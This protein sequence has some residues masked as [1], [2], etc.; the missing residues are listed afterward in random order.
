M[1]KWPTLY[2]YTSSHVLLSILE[3]RSIWLGTRQ[4]LNDFNEGEVF[5]SHL[6][7]Y[8]STTGVKKANVDAVV[9]K[10][11]GLECYVNCMTTNGDQLSQWRGYAANGAGVSIGFNG[12]TLVQVI[13]GS[14]VALLRKVNY[15]DDFGTLEKETQDLIAAVLK[16]GGDPTCAFVQSLAKARWAIKNKAFEE[17]CEYRLILTPGPDDSAIVF[18]SG[19]TAVRKYRA[20]ESDIREYYELSFRNVD[21]NDLIQKVVLGPR[22][23][24][25]LDA[26]RRLLRDK[27]FTNVDVGKSVA[28]YR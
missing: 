24:S 18:K 6:R 19:E 25:D 13:N 26:V 10:L 21:P 14:Q 8:A 5:F 3:H 28:S 15:G 1:S 22:N 23:A 16:S 17:E 20:S 2:H 12:A 27:G 7:S 9:A 4:H 11:T